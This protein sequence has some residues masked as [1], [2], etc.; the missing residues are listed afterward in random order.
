M[1]ITRLAPGCFLSRDLAHNRRNKKNF[2]EIDRNNFYFRKSQLSLVF[3]SDG[4]V[5][6]VQVLRSIERYDLVKIKPTE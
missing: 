6:G 3:T 2:K 5:F 1:H 4:V